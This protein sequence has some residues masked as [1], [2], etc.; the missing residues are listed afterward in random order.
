[1][2]PKSKDYLIISNLLRMASDEFSNKNCNDIDSELI[3][4]LTEKEKDELLSEIN[5]WNGNTLEGCNFESVHEIPDFILMN[6]YAD[7]L[8]S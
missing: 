5:K 6:F 7:K 3:H 2:R 8:Q 1:M 4:N